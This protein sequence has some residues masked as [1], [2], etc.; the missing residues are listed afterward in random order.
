M[1][2]VGSRSQLPSAVREDFLRML[3]P[4][5]S[6]VVAPTASKARLTWDLRVFSGFAADG[7]ELN[8][9]L[10]VFAAA[11]A[12]REGVAPC[13]A[14]SARTVF[15]SARFPTRLL[16]C[17][18]PPCL[19]AQA[20]PRRPRSRPATSGRP[21]FREDS[22]AAFS[23]LHLIRSNTFVLEQPPFCSCRPAAPEF[24]K[25][26]AMNS[27]PRVRVQAVPGRLHLRHRGR[28][29]ARPPLQAAKRAFPDGPGGERKY[30]E[31]ISVGLWMR[32]TAG[33][34]RSFVAK[35]RLRATGGLPLPDP[36]S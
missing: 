17:R 27:L 4:I 15:S 33:L 5:L 6:N 11:W 9:W 30:I 29:D 1:P 12:L 16:S 18:F 2:Q 8:P 32:A 35:S 23:A 20:C 13:C 26:R 14:P 21:T 7:I 34:H 31:S 22:A 25:T 36:R 24:P 28:H 10:N 19:L 3:Q